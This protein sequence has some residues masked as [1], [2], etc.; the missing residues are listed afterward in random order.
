MKGIPFL[1][2]LTI[3]GFVLYGC[4]SDSSQA[5]PAAISVVPGVVVSDEAVLK[6]SSNEDPPAWEGEFE[7]E[8]EPPY[9]LAVNRINNNFVLTW[10][11]RV[12]VAGET[13][14]I[15]RDGEQV[16]TISAM[17]YE[18]PLPQRGEPYCFAVFRN[19]ATESSAASNETC[20]QSSTSSGQIQV[21]ESPSTAAINET[22][23]VVGN[24]EQ[25][26][27]GLYELGIMGPGRKTISQVSAPT[28]PNSPGGIC[29]LMS[30]K[31]T[32]TISVY[33]C[34]SPLANSEEEYFPI[35]V[36]FQSGRSTTANYNT[37]FNS[38]YWDR[39]NG[40]FY[41]GALSRYHLAPNV[42]NR[43]KLTLISRT[44]RLSDIPTFDYFNA[45]KF[46]K[47]STTIICPFILYS[48]MEFQC[49]AMQSGL[50]V[51]SIQHDHG[52]RFIAGNRF[53]VMVE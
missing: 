50:Y 36:R 11:I 22:I 13:I 33:R 16:D 8:L 35:T 10:Q 2:G 53:L 39:Y 49:P 23:S 26:E 27:N 48:P 21:V 15:I 52:T 19:T 41:V 29:A 1:I 51:V 47:G 45:V 7:A 20:V 9:S 18:T 34:T 42:E 12:R 38:S 32:E 40:Q 46:E 17:Q 6:T 25:I 30:D 43:L 5:T 44:L 31:S 3:Y 28:S 4:G 37:V 14:T 24:W